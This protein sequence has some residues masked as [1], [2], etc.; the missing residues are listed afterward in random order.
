MRQP[1][2]FQDKQHPNHIFHLL[3]S[4]YNLKQSP[5]AWF[6]HLHNL[7]VKIWFNEGI[8]D[9]LLFVY[10]RDGVTT[11]LLVY[12]DDIV[13]T[14]SSPNIN[15]L[16]VDQ[17]CKEFMIKNLGNLTYFLGI[18]VFRTDEGIF[19]SQQQYVANLLDG[20]NLGHLKP[21]STPMEPKVDLSP[22]EALELGPEDATR[23]MRVLGCLQYLM[24]T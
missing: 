2:G 22:A 24:T 11:Y 5:H 17:L 13:N 21:S 14:S 20:E 3:K 6:H 9:P 1:L 23:F 4:I 8:S 10:L 18:H 15:N 7:L 19:L 12:V 16:I